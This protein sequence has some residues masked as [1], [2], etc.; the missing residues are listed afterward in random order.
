MSRVVEPNEAKVIVDKLYDQIYAL[1]VTELAD[2]NDK[3]AW[4]LMSR[5]I[6]SLFGIHYGISIKKSQ[7]AIVERVTNG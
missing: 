7:E 3:Q 2:I 1:I 4:L 6:N 5:V